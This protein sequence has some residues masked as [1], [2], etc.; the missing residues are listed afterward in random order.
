MGARALEAYARLTAAETSADRR[1]L[2]LA[3]DFY[4]SV[5]A[6]GFLRRAEELLPATA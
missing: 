4:R 5:S 3:I 6:T 2:G 1:Q